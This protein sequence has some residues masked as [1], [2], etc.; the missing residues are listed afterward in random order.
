MSLWGISTTTETE[1]NNYA[2]PKF[3]DETDRNIT[4]HNCFADER[5]WIFRHYQS[6]EHSGLSTTYYDE[7]LVPVA[8]LNTTGIGSHSTGIGT[9]TPVAVF[10]EDPNQ[11]SPISIGAGGTTG[12]ST[13]AVGY[14]HV[15]Y[16][17]LVQ[18]TAGCSI[19]IKQY[20]NAGVETS[21]P[22]T[23]VANAYASGATVYNYF[24]GTGIAASTSHNGQI[25]NRIA[26]EF[27]VP[28]DKVGIG[29]F[30]K[31]DV[32]SGVSTVGGAITSMSGEAV[33]TVLT[34]DLI[35]NVGGAGTYVPAGG[36]V[37]IGTTTLQIL[38]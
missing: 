2:L 6:S 27:T 12:I 7:V 26:F 10:F 4:E 35:R 37:G 5:G 23:A 30:L 16:N 1:A 34:D 21:S 22:I 3:L 14:V 25:T 38:A 8:G 24:N 15:V 13:A 29:S 20:T 36:G 11:A 33:L 17:E 19:T 32:T 28:G 18:V 9:A 31:I